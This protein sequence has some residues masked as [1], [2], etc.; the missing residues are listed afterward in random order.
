M[1]HFFTSYKSKISFLLVGALLLVGAFSFFQQKFASAATQAELQQELLRL[2]SELQQLQAQIAQQQTQ[3]EATA[4]FQFTRNLT[5]GSR[6]EDVQQLQKVLNASFATVVAQSGPGSPGNETDYFGSLTKSAVKRFQEVH[7][8]D[9]LLPVGL[10]TGTGFVGPSTRDKLNEISDKGNMFAGTQAP[11]ITQ[12]VPQYATNGSTITIT[13]TEFAST[14]SVIIGGD[15][16]ENIPS[17]DGKTMQVTVKSSAI[18]DLLTV[19]KESPLNVA[20]QLGAQNPTVAAQIKDFFNQSPSDPNLTYYEALTPEQKQAMRL[21]TGLI[22]DE[23]VAVM[24]PEQQATVMNFLATRDPEERKYYTGANISGAIPHYV[25][26]TNKN[27]ES[28]EAEF[29]LQLFE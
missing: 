6:G 1:T 18:E 2:L 12:I 26:V 17:S 13:G 5:V 28:K 29:Y 19:D 11:Q 3:V 15:L 9:V 7:F 16:Y 23:L 21:R 8:E 25:I 27:G 24:T 14:N 10:V 4:G 20:N 22:T